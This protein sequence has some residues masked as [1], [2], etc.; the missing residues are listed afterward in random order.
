[1]EDTVSQGSLDSATGEEYVVVNADPK[2]KIPGNGCIDDLEEK[3]SEVLK[4]DNMS[5]SKEK[6]GIKNDDLTTSGDTIT[7]ESPDSTRGEGEIE[8]SKVEADD[9]GTE[10][11]SV[12]E[13]DIP[14][15]IPTTEERKTIGDSTFFSCAVNRPRGATNMRDSEASNFGDPCELITKSQTGVMNT[16]GCE[17]SWRLRSASLP[18]TPD[19]PEGQYTFFSNVTYLGSASINAPR[20]EAEINR[21]MEILNEH[22]QLSIPITLAVPSNS[23]GLVRLLEPSTNSE[24]ATFKVH[25]ILFCAR[26]AVETNERKCFAFTC[27][28][29]DSAD[30]VLFQC[31]VFRCEIQDAV[32]KILYCFATSFRKIPRHSFSAGSLS[33]ITEDSNFHF[34]VFMEVKEEDGKGN[35]SAC[36]KDKN[37][38]KLRVNLE[39]KI[40]VTMQQ[41]SNKELK[42]E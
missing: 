8:M 17:E 39:K 36:P 42:I 26:G 30:A 38:F 14:R 40:S 12:G 29:G 9:K 25:R 32:G 20:S 1:M 28:H 6:E 16:A 4:D 24:I 18:N 3:L 2:L 19:L 37:A 31:H 5:G 7:D 13:V 11:P 15:N 33:S 41:T 27:S 23:E 34:D 35:F 21:N 22:S 10:L